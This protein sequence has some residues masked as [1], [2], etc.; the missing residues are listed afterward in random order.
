MIFNCSSLNRRDDQDDGDSVG[1]MINDE[2][3]IWK[4]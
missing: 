3:E 1:I 4:R 2:D